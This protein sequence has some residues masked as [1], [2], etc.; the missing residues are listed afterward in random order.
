V[1]SNYTY[2]CARKR[3]ACISEIY[4][5]HSDKA[6]NKLKDKITDSQITVSEKYLANYT[7]TNWLHVIACSNDKRALKLD[8]YDRRW[9]I[10][11]VVEETQDKAYWD[12]FYHWLRC[13]GG[14]G[15]IMAELQRFA[16][17]DGNV[18]GRSE[19]AP[20]SLAKSEMIEEGYSEGQKFVLELLKS[21]A[22]SANG[23]A[24]VLW[25]EDLRELVKVVIHQGRTDRLEK[26]QTIRKVAKRA[27]WHLG[28]DRVLISQ[29]GMVRK[30]KLIST[31][32]KV[33]QMVASTYNQ[34]KDQIEVVSGLELMVKV[35]N[36]GLL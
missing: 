5:G 4:Q 11:T 3:L 32:P 18:I 36:K 9:F 6:Y 28:K 35:Q 14:Y 20:D 25:D 31:N 21:E 23:K 33:A 1:D 27:G 7:I 34:F 8:D 15:I 19:R 16:K 12:N 26:C 13:C 10:P 2:Y 22:D 17:E 29:I 30:A 24:L